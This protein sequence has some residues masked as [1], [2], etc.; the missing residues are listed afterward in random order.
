MPKGKQSKGK[1]KESIEVTFCI[2]GKVLG[3]HA[4]KNIL[5]GVT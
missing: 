4:L 3:P 1:I 2:L 5:N